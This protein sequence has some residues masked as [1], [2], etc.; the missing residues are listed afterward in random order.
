MHA[1]PSVPYKYF[2]PTSMKTK[3]SI[4]H[5]VNKIMKTTLTACA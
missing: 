5:N 4:S 1:N 2:H 3:N